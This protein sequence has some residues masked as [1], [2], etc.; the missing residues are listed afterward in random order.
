MPPPS[1]GSGPIAGVPPAPVYAQQ[2]THFAS[3]P[4]YSL[5]PSNSALSRPT[6]APA[7]P[8]GMAPPSG[9]VRDVSKVSW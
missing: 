7:G 2:P 1:T 8:S 9:L 4:G 5:P 6:G 3:H